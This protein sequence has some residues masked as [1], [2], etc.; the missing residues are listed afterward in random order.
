MKN[1][2][3][4]NIAIGLLAVMVAISVLPITTAF[5]QEEK[6]VN[7]EKLAQVWAHQLE[8]YEKLGKLFNNSDEILSKVQERI[9]KAKS[10]GKDVSKLQAALD[11]FED[12]L[13]N[14]RPVYQSMNGIVTSHQGFDSSGKVID[15]AKAIETVKQ[16]HE[17]MQ[18][19]KTAMNGTGK[20]LREAIKEF[21]EANP[22]P[23]NRP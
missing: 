14:A 12:A 20:A 21:R 9:D 18:A 3:L 15:Q 22:R 23:G 11:A 7:A 4:R 5:A 8:R 17:K 16:M 1:M 6:P 13:K 2:I 10:A 19:L